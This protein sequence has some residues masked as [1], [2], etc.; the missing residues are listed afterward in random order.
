MRT[1]PHRRPGN[2][3]AASA[4]DRLWA[5]GPNHRRPG[6]RSRSLALNVRTTLDLILQ[7]IQFTLKV[8]RGLIN[9]VK[10]ENDFRASV[11]GGVG[12]SIDEIFRL[13]CPLPQFG[14]RPLACTL[15]G[16]GF[17][18][19]DRNRARQILGRERSQLART[20]RW[21][22]QQALLMR[23]NRGPK[24]LFRLLAS[25][26]VDMTYIARAIYRGLPNC[27]AGV[28]RDKALAGLRL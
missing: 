21:P 1:Q 12:Y 14:Q 2:A 24:K 3:V 16:V 22:P 7:A 19:H 11:S 26:V 15:I 17:H 27:R 20:A 10:L 6:R 18:F 28:P 4:S 13:L 9:T 5:V 8:L 23:A 25:P